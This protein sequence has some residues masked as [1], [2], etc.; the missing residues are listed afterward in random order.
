MKG[1]TK[2]SIV[3]L[4]LLMVIGFAAV[5]TTLTINGVIRL[6]ANQENFKNNLIF[7]K[8]ELTYS[9]TNKTVAEGEVTI[10]EDKKGINFNTQ[11]LKNIGENVTLTYDVTNNSQY[12]AE[13]KGIICTVTNAEGTDVTE[14]VNNNTEYITL[15]YTKNKDAEGNNAKISANGGVL[16]GET[17][18]VTLR[19]SYVGTETTTTTNYSV[20]CTINASGLSE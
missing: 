6:G 5:T 10:S 9:D 2:K 16:T 12:G 17:L 15:E 7:T 8:A 18:K 1:K 11:E 13:F 19:K 3:V 4:V 20:N 14:A